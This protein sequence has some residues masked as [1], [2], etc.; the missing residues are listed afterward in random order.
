MEQEWQIWE[1]E[2]REKMQQALDAGKRY[3]DRLK[4]WR[5]AVTAG[6]AVAVLGIVLFAIELYTHAFTIAPV[7]LI[8]GG[9][10]IAR[11]QKPEIDETRELEDGDL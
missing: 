10:W 11:T 8:A 9:I 7:L 1:I 4:T 5:K 3:T 6:K 2:E